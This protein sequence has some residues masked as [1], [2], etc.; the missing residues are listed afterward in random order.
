MND[1]RQI[2]IL[3]HKSLSQPAHTPSM[4]TLHSEING[5]NNTVIW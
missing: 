2:R 1:L 4:I 3:L 5:S